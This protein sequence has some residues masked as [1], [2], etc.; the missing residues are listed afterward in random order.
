MLDEGDRLGARERLLVATLE[1]TDELGVGRATTRQIAERAGANLQLI[2]YYFG[3]KEGLILEAER[4][5]LERFFAEIGP[6]VAGADTLDKAVR[7]GIAATWDL[8][9]RQPAMVQPDL[10]LQR[11]RAGRV[12]AAPDRPRQTHV[13]VAELLQGVMERSG[14]R[15]AIPLESFV[16]ILIAGLSGLVLEYRVTHDA[17]SIGAAVD[18]F[19]DVLA[20]LVEP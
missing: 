16:L 20:G 2:G 8:A 18:R 7:Q 5:I 13:R 12:D 10:L 3:G 6:A 19:A 9:R 11:V 1:T 4:F 17:E 15:L 14:G